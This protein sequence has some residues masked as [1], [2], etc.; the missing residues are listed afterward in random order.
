ME[1]ANGMGMLLAELFATLAR[2]LAANVNDVG[3][4]A[5]VATKEGRIEDETRL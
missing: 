3:E 4:L 5:K 2:E 1:G